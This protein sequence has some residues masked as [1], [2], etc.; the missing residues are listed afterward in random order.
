MKGQAQISAT[1]LNSTKEKLDR[2]TSERGLKKDY[3][4]EQA[5]LYFMEAR[6]D[7]PGEALIPTRILLTDER[8][9][10]LATLLERPPAPTDPL[11]ELMRSS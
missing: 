9:D 10:R 1:I 4:V 7:L 2:F 11:R 5:L 8:F 6:R 3:V